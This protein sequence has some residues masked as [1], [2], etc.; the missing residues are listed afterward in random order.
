MKAWFTQAELSALLH[1]GD[2]TTRRLL[3][4]YRKQC[5]MAR[6]GSHPRLLLWIPAAVVTEICEARGELWRTLANQGEQERMS[7]QIVLD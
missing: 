5:H 3:K 7:G 4:P 1:V 6:H 2:R